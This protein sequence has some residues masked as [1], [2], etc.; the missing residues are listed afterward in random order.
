MSDEAVSQLNHWWK[1][2]EVAHPRCVV[3][4]SAMEGLSYATR[5]ALTKQFEDMRQLQQ[6]YSSKSAGIS[7]LRSNPLPGTTYFLSSFQV[8]ATLQNLTQRYT[9]M[10]RL[11]LH[12]HP[13][14]RVWIDKQRL[15]LQLQEELVRSENVQGQARA[16]ILQAQQ[17]SA[18]IMQQLQKKLEETQREF[19]RLLEQYD[20]HVQQGGHEQEGKQQT[21]A[22]L[23]KEVTQ[24]EEKERSARNLQE[25][26]RL[27]HERDVKTL[28]E[29]KWSAVM[30]KSKVAGGGVGGG[31]Q[32]EGREGE[33]EER[34]KKEA[35][36][37]KEGE[38]EKRR[39]DKIRAKRT[40]GR[41]RE[42][43]RA[44]VA[45]A[46]KREGRREEEERD[47]AQGFVR[48]PP[49]LVSSLPLPLESTPSKILPPSANSSSIP[50]A[51]PSNK[52]RSPR[53]SLSGESGV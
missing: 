12:Q 29:Y 28:E 4:L 30:P 2:T 16:Q 31:M 9:D 39:K 35:V 44:E 40:R 17:I 13:M 14:A 1:L 6:E 46:A 11:W 34:E 41:K 15:E 7:I 51:S 49:P 27:Q 22:E 53:S 50:P 23:L 38:K 52:E 45:R 42:R 47:K 33:G 32:M 18:Q 21:I 26:R 36:E 25:K 48:S 8:N 10:L 43:E 20:Q 37:E 3:E 24:Q 5:Q 19:K